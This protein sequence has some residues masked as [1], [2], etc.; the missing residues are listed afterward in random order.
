MYDTLRAEAGLLGKNY[1]VNP[2][3]VP[4]AWIIQAWARRPAPGEKWLSSDSRQPTDAGKKLKRKSISL[5][6]KPTEQAMFHTAVTVEL[7]AP[8]IF[9]RTTV[10]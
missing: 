3:F 10:A 1:W 7:L 8:D 5:S 2:R 9:E 4:F 6:K